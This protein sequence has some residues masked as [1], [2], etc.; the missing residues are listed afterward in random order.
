MYLDRNTM[1]TEKIETH[2]SMIIY[3]AILILINEITVRT[4]S[5]NRT[6][7]GEYGSVIF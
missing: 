6:Q 2:L 7:I 5:T 1:A 4:M 3:F